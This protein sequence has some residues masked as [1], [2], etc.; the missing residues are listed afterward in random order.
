[1][2]GAPRRVIK[3]TALEQQ[4]RKRYFSATLVTCVVVA[5]VFGIAHVVK[6]G[7]NRMSDMRS[8]VGYD[9]RDEVTHIRAAGEDIVLHRKHE[10]SARAD[11]IYASSELDAL[12]S[13]DEASEIGK[14]VLVPAGSF[15]MG[16]GAV[17][18]DLQDQPQHDVQLPDYHID[19]Y[20][21]TN[22]QYARFVAETRRRP[23]LDWVDGR[24]PDMK[25]LHPVVM[26]SWYDAEA[27][28]AF[29]GKRLPTEAE[30]EK[31][32]RSTDGRRWPWGNVMDPERLNTY[33]HIGSTT[34]VLKYTKGQS[35]YGVMDL[36]GNV[37]EWTASIFGPYAGSSAP[38]NMF[39]PKAV[40][41]QTTKDRAMKV[42]DQVEL[43]KGD[44]RVRRG[45]SWKS[46]P[47]ATSVYH[48]NYTLPHYASDFFG[49]RCASDSES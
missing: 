12:I 22:I 42:A 23:P 45:G 14:T 24:M 5:L 6:L 1:M 2:S 35:A 36:A 19:K 41:A 30:W 17:R 16:T 25:M 4:R 43:G 20:P 7:A 46:D 44:Y 33:Y 37:S 3:I 18:A 32:A 38:G 21:V 39:R 11:F 13:A 8:K 29:A 49:F 28:C 26:V 31:A 9:I 10:E 15:I 47:F 40:V 34:K 27:Y 48:R